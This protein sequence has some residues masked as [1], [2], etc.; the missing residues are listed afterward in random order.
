M[1][2]TCHAVRINSLTNVIMVDWL[3]LVREGVEFG[4]L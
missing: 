2:T 3:F 1:T 4:E